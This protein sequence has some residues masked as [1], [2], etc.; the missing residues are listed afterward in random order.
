MF[1]II[2]MKH[3]TAYFSHFSWDMLPQISVTFPF[4]C[5]IICHAAMPGQVSCTFHVLYP[6]QVSCIFHAAVPVIIRASFMHLPCYSPSD[7]SCT[8]LSKFHA[9]SIMQSQWWF[10]QVSCI[11]HAAV[12]VMICASFMH[13]PWCI[14]Q[15]V[16]ISFH[17]ACQSKFLALFV[18]KAE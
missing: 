17:A 4:G 1:H 18:H 16:D 14:P 10:M 9:S 11:F 7:D 12:P 15:Q 6:W 2:F 13:R 3:S 5:V 8:T